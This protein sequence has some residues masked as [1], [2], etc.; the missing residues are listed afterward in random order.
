MK[1]WTKKHLFK[2]TINEKA[3]GCIYI[4]VESE[5]KELY[6]RGSIMGDYD[7]ITD[8]KGEKILNAMELMFDEKAKRY[9]EK[10]GEY[11]GGKEWEEGLQSNN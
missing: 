5:T 8:F 7:V 11:K 1:I 6:F 2:K 3:Y 10:F 9:D 4:L